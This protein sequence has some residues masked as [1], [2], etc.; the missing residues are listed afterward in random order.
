MVD[1]QRALLFEDSST[2]NGTAY[3][4]ARWFTRHAFQ[5]EADSTVTTATAKVQGR[6][7]ADAQWEDIGGTGTSAL[8]IAAGTNSI[9][10]VYDE[11]FLEVRGVLS[12][13]AGTG[14]ARIIYMGS[15]G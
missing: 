2:G 7:S 1:F 8:S 3:D 10:E 15:R 4:G 11:N 12:T 6:L 14:N 5:L 13:Y 9:T